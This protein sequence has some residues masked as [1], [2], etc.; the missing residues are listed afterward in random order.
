MVVVQGDHYNQSRLGTVIVSAVTSNTA[1]ASYPGNVF[2][3]ANATELS[4]DS[5][6]NVT[7]LATVDRAALQGRIGTLPEYLQRDLDEGLRLVLDV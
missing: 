1:L 7:A 3:P 6:I 2:I 5:V 4:R